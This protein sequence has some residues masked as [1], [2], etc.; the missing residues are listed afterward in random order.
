MTTANAWEMG[1]QTQEQPEQQEEEGQA[2][3]RTINVGE[4]ERWISAG[5][6][7]LLALYGFKRL[8]A[9]GILVGTGGVLL[10]QRALTGH[11]PLYEK[12][13]LNTAT[14]E[15]AAPKEYFER[16]I[17]VEESFTIMKSPEELYSFWHNFE[18]LPRFMKH[19]KSV[20]VLDEKR[21]HWV[22]DGPAGMDVEWYAEII[23]DEPN[24]LIAWR[25]LGGADVDN[26]GSVTFRPA[27][28]DRGTKV[29][30]V[31]DYIPPAG[32]AGA[33]IAKLFGHDADQLVREDLRNFKRLMETGEIPTTEGQPMGVCR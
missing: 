19:L 17:H 23:N 16:G 29:S 8:S 28:G 4:Q 13:G 5:I 14:G 27:P 11:C 7:A 10:L 31:I 22:A 26:A 33:W 12:L 15:G 18:N 3:G 21:S 20:K 6:G 25:S 2:S 30:V 9:A 1:Q 24:K 32:K